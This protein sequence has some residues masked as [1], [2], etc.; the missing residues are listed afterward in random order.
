MKKLKLKNYYAKS[1]KKGNFINIKIKEI[2]LKPFLTSISLSRR[3]LK[4]F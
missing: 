3:L 1:L 2:V 4:Y